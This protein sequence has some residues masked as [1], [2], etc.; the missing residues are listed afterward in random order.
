M[1]IG[2]LNKQTGDL[3]WFDAVTNLSDSYSGQVTTKPIETGS[4]ISDHVTVHNN[5]INFN[6]IISDVDF[7]VNVVQS[8]NQSTLAK[9]NLDV[10]IFNF[11]GESDFVTVNT[12]APNLLSVFTPFLT[13]G[14]QVPSVNVPT[15]P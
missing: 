15:R 10:R 4:V 9:N 12:T 11:T 8:I 14:D 5:G 13:D 1:S 3:I 7:N 2:L 6:G